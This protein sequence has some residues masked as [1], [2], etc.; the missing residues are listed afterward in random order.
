VLIERRMTTRDRRGVNAGPLRA[1]SL[2]S[3]VAEDLDANPRRPAFGREVIAGV[4][5]GQVAGVAMAAALMAVFSTFLNK[6]LFFPLHIIAASVLGESAI[7]RL[8][9][10]TTL[11]VGLLVHQLGPS[12]VWGVVFGVV[13]WLFKPRRSLALMTL[14]LLVGALSQV[15]DVHLLL[16][17]VLGRIPLFGLSQSDKLWAQVPIVTSW[18]AHLVFGFALS[19]YP[20]KYDPIAQGFD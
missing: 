9:A 13:V 17:L 2:L 5:A 6:G 8:D 19:L 3:P 20:W 16:P 14:G 10:R 4:Q 7:G 11:V 1:R 18:F 12:L 15:V